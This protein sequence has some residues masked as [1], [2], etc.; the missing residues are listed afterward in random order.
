MRYLRFKSDCCFRRKV[1]KSCFS[2]VALMCREKDCGLDS[3]PW[4][5]LLW[6]YWCCFSKRSNGWGSWQCHNS[7]PGATL[8]TFWGSCILQQLESRV[9]FSYSDINGHQISLLFCFVRFGSTLIIWSDMHNYFCNST[10]GVRF[11]IDVC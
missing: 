7:L 8:L 4:L 3:P 6:A 10:S 11:K 9:L 1:F 5:L 2:S